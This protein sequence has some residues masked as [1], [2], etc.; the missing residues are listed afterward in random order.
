MKGVLRLSPGIQKNS[1]YA[2]YDCGQPFP[3]AANQSLQGIFYFSM[4]F[5]ETTADA[6]EQLG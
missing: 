6:R 4:Y 3:Q 2:Y 5:S 1:I